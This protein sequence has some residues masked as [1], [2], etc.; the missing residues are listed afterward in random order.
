MLSEVQKTILKPA[1]IEGVGLHSGLETTLILKP[2]LPNTGIL[3]VRKDIK[4]AKKNSIQANFKNVSSA[5]LCTKVEN[6]FGVSVSTIEHLMAAFYGEGI[7]NIIVEINNKEIPIM[8]GSAMAFV[9]AIR[10]SGIRQQSVVRKF[11]KVLKKV[12]ITNDSKY[13]SIEPFEKELKI[14]FKLIYNNSLIGSQRDALVINKKNLEKVYNARTFCLYEDIEKIKA[15]GLAK[16]GSLDNAIVVQGE[17]VLNKEGLR[18]KKEFVKH[19]ILDCLGD[20]ML[21][22]HRIF[23]LVKTVRGGH[24]L[25]NDLLQKF[26]SDSTNW[27]FVSS[28]KEDLETNKN[29][30]Y[31]DQ[32]AVNA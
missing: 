15:T 27:K 26:F 19:K 4:D 1:K 5:K 16:G 3:F 31:T 23:G 28:K 12:E 25:T 10:S 29:Y 14:D 13:I 21:S 18:D 6:S 2:A 20:F 7:D 17:K 24:Q 30:N 22:E 9:K 11:I 8:D 32:I